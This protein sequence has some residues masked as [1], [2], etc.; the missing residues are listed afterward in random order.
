VTS[1]EGKKKVSV[2]IL[3]TDQVSHCS[4]NPSLPNFCSTFSPSARNLA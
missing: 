3:V 4:R 1:A 2:N